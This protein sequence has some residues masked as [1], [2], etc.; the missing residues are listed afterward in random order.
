MFWSETVA[1]SN[2]TGVMKKARRGVGRVYCSK[3]YNLSRA[4][5]GRRL[6]FSPCYFSG[7]LSL[8]SIINS[9]RP[10]YR[11]GVQM[12]YCSQKFKGY[13]AWENPKSEGKGKLIIV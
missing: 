3:P 8:L 5:V 4:R 9:R 6:I 12:N 1:L 7:L 2:E 13:N 11:S 10:S